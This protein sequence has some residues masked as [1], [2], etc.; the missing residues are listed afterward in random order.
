MTTAKDL[1]APGLLDPAEAVRR[2]AAGSQDAA[3]LI[4]V[5]EDGRGPVVIYTERRADMRKHPGEISFP[6]GRR[7]DGEP[8]LT[9]ALR[10]ADEEIGLGPD[11][12]EVIGAL[13]PMGTVVTRYRIYPFVGVVAAGPDWTPSPAEVEQ[14]LEVPLDQLVSVYR[15]ERLWEKRIPIRTPTFRVDGHLIWGATARLTE[16]LLLRVRLI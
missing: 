16:Q 14:V 15:S 4:P 8:L 12:V 9:T 7:D 10:E 13:A 5:V 11:R 1:L 2:T 6:G 3:V